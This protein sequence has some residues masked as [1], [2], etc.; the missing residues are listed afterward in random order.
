M[1]YNLIQQGLYFLE[2]KPC[3]EAILLAGPTCEGSQAAKFE[4]LE[5]ESCSD[6]TTLKCPAGVGI[7]ML[8]D[9]DTV[10]SWPGSTG[11]S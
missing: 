1:Q 3:N 2:L 11:R 10:F 8:L 7:N 6:C 5:Q 4:R 9:N